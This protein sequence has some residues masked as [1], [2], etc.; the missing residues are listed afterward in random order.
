MRTLI[1]ILC[2]FVLSFALIFFTFFFCVQTDHKL[3]TKEVEEVTTTTTT[4]T[5][6]TTTTTTTKKTT[7]KKT[8]K[9]TTK[10]IEI[11]DVV[12]EEDVATKDGI[13]LEDINFSNLTEIIKNQDWAS[14]GLDPEIATYI[15]NDYDTSIYYDEWRETY[16]DYL[17]GKDVSYKINRDRVEEIVKRAIKAYNDDHK[18]KPIDEEKLNGLIKDAE[19]KAEEALDKANDNEKLMNALRFMFNEQYK[20]YAMIAVIVCLVLIILLNGIDAVV[21]LRSPFVINSVL[22]FVSLFIL[23]RFSK[24]LSVA[25]GYRYDCIMYNTRLFGITYLVIG[26]ICLIACILIRNYIKLKND[27]IVK[28]QE[29]KREEKRKNR[30]KEDEEEEEE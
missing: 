8:E 25:L 30:N 9:T 22:C 7:T 11:S 27:P 13:K 3:F 20:K 14:K 4:T 21:Y 2:S 10:E 12:K 29:R 6:T 5:S 16:I 1:S 26:I 19:D 17:S 28:E 15:I 18:D 24:V 23:D